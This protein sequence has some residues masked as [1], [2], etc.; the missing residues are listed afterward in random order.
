MKSRIVLSVALLASFGVQSVIAADY[1][2]S[3]NAP[4]QPV[5]VPQPVAVPPYNWTGGYVG[6]NAGYGFATLTETISIGQATANSN[7]PIAGGQIG[8]NFQNGPYVFGVEVDG[9]WSD[10]ARSATQHNLF[11]RQTS[12]W[13][14]P[15]SD[16]NL[17]TRLRQYLR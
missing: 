6:L 16:R 3:V 7:G 8:G 10:H 5:Y 2:E 13:L 17:P 12:R 9:Q 4:Q 1:P 14:R 15:H 11:R